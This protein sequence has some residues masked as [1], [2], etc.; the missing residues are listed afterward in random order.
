MVFTNN[1]IYLK[2]R[3]KMFFLFS[4]VKSLSTNRRIIALCIFSFFLFP[5]DRTRFPLSTLYTICTIA[6]NC[7][8]CI[9]FI[10]AFC[11][12]FEVDSNKRRKL[13]CFLI[14]LFMLS[15]LV[16]ILSLTAQEIF[17]CALYTKR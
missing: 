7:K 2:Y 14:R 3:I 1:K 4:S 10:N 16:E 17:S 8:G 12:W 6:F 11:C 13:P 5:F 9:V 15:F